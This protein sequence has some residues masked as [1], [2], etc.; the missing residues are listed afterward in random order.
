MDGVVHEILG[1]WDLIIAHPPCTY[2]SNAGA[3]RLYKRFNDKSYVEL[4][5][6]EKGWTARQFFKACLYADCD[7]VAVENPTPSGVFH[8]PKQTQ[9]IQPY[10]FG[11]PYTKRTCLWLRGLNKLNPTNIVKPLGPWVC[12]NSEIWKKQGA[13]GTV[14]GKEKDARHRSLTFWGVAQA[15]AEQW[16]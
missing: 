5:R 1:K 8:L 6:F 3:A 16:G 15:M 10:E 14:Y 11:H 4:E 12:G 13:N 2:I 7:H 9:I